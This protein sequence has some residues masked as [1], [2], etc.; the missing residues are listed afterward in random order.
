MGRKEKPLDRSSGPLAELA[1]E[2]RC[3]RT[4]AGLT[5]RQ[6]AA[7]THYSASALARAASGTVRPSLDLV[8]AYAAACGSD[9][10]RW[11]R[12]WQALVAPP[13]AGR[14][15]PVAPA[16]P[17]PDDGPHELPPD[18]A[19]F[20]GRERE[21]SGA[22]AA[23][24]RWDQGARLVT[25]TGMAGVGKSAFAIRLAHRLGPGYHDGQLYLRLQLSD[26]RPKPATACLAHLLR[27]LGEADRDRTTDAT[28]DEQTAL[29]RSRIAGRRFIVVLDDAIDEGQVRA[30]I[31]PPPSPTI[32]TSRGPL[33]ALEGAYRVALDAMT[34]AEAVEMLARIAGPARVRVSL[35]AA[36]STAQ[37]C[38]RLPLAIRVAGARMSA[39]PG[40]T[41]GD[42]EQRLRTYGRLSELCAGDLA[43]RRELQRSY[44]RLAE[45]SR[46]LL[47]SL[48]SLPG[49]RF[50]AAATEALQGAGPATDRALQGLV[51]A[52]LVVA[53]GPGPYYQIPELVRLFAVER[54]EREDRSASTQ[55]RQ[56]L[57]TWYADSAV[58]ACDAVA[59]LRREVGPCSR[60]VRGGLAF[61]DDQTAWRWLQHERVNLVRT[62]QL[63]GARG[64]EAAW[65]I[66]DAL[67]AFFDRSRRVQDWRATAVAGLCAAVHARERAAAA[68]M[69]TSLG[70]AGAAA[71]NPRAAEVHLRRALL[72]AQVAGAPAA[73]A[74]ALSDLAD[75][76]LDLGR[77]T[78]AHRYQRAALRIWRSLGD[79]TGEAAALAGL[80]RVARRGGRLAASLRLHEQALEMLAGTESRAGVVL[81]LCQR[82]TGHRLLGRFGPARSDGEQALSL[83]LDLG[84]RY[85]Q[86]S[87]RLGLA[88]TAL[89]RGDFS[90]AHRDCEAALHAG[91]LVGGPRLYVAGLLLL[92]RAQAGLGQRTAVR[93][94]TMAMRSARRAR[95]SEMDLREAAGAALAG[96][97]D[98]PRWLDAR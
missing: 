10:E 29:Y 20:V 60:P 91:R 23:L 98:L 61:S 8:L 82:A 59:G 6:M 56:R 70:Q 15:A 53:G 1:S 80:A 32:V 94:R 2:L 7:A 81:A 63:G 95:L 12:R 52:N 22:I 41:I 47:R 19:D 87:A 18:I 55:A 24:A 21:L 48:G 76:T 38:D 57:A 75:A 42:L 69:L 31:A 73:R 17:P 26:G 50:S 83:A 74:F 44:E 86:S 16:S 88:A 49:T 33:A 25:V 96:E 77:I 66:A 79:P 40:W 90:A 35:P 84:F 46:R 45:P 64:W 71:G 67:R 68:A 93:T 14:R 9:G 78:T 54:A 11:R 43:V 3:L 27:G 30:L 65:V 4:E 34:E 36:R 89:D 5:Y 13:A 37:M 58:A 92:A 51:E 39:R 28:L 85:G 97:R 72:L 62:V